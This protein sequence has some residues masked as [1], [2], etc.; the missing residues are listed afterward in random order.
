[1]SNF[2]QYFTMSQVEGEEEEL[3]KCNF[4]VLKNH[5]VFS[6]I[7]ISYPLAGSFDYNLDLNKYLGRMPNLLFTL[8]SM[9]VHQHTLKR[10]ITH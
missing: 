10:K 6:Q 5:L 9:Q 7:I 1:M 2:K 8:P 3:L 4:D